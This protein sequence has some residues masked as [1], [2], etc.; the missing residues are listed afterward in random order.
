MSKA[1]R[2]RAQVDSPSLSDASAETLQ[3]IVQEALVERTQEQVADEA[4]ITRQAVSKY[5]TGAQKRCLQRHID[6][7]AKALRVDRERIIA[8][9]RR[10][11]RGKLDIF[12][13]T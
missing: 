1:K 4:G 13:R 6:P 9:V 2:T 7:L 10:A 11:V 8:A 3:Q 5:A 12:K